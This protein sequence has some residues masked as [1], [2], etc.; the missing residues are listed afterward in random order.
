M[1]VSRREW[2]DFG[3]DMNLLLL[4]QQ[5]VLSIPCLG[6]F[7]V[8]PSLEKVLMLHDTTSGRAWKSENSK[9]SPFASMRAE[10]WR[11]SSVKG[12]NLV[13]VTL[14]LGVLHQLASLDRGQSRRDFNNA[15]AGASIDFRICLT[16]VIEDIHH[17]SSVSGTHFV[18]EK[19]MVRIQ[20]QLVV[21]D[22]MAGNSFTIVWAEE[23]SRPDL[24]SRCIVGHIRGRMTVHQEPYCGLYRL[25]SMKSRINIRTLLGRSF[26]APCCL[27]FGVL[28]S[29]GLCIAS[30][31]CRDGAGLVEPATRRETP[32][33]KVRKAGATMRSNETDK[34]AGKSTCGW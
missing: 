20:L 25:S 15:E 12:S 3:K 17:Q 9:K 8:S 4:S 22:Q 32:S 10:P 24:Q 11:G 31:S 2:V 30:A 1:V 18:D 5:G 29:S 21:C 27:L 19:V 16:D 33:S 14:C 13:G 23:F 34:L 6:I 26:L 7:D 28:G